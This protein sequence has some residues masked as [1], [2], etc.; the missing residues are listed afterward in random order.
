MQEKEIII[1]VRKSDGPNGPSW[2][3]YGFVGKDTFVWPS[4]DDGICP[5]NRQP[6]AAEVEAFDRYLR[7]PMIN[8][9]PTIPTQ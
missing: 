7:D 2:L 1:S 8:E 4:N 5:I 6:S 9:Y 3:M